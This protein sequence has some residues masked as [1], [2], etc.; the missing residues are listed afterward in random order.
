MVP[1][2]QHLALLSRVE[3]LEKELS[4]IK[5]LQSEWVTTSEAKIITG[6][7]SC[8]ALKRKRELPDAI[9]IVRFEG[10]KPLYLRSSLVAYCDSK[11]R[12]PVLPGRNLA[13]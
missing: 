11:I 1:W 13:G 2:E 8:A 9:I 4:V 3:Q 5:A 7:K 6:I 10:K 12:K